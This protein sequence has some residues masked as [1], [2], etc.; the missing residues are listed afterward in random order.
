MASPS[1]GA[2]MVSRTSAPEASM[3]LKR[4]FISFPS[5]LFGEPSG[6]AGWFFSHYL[7]NDFRSN[8]PPR[9]PKIKII[10]TR[11]ESFQ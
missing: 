7:N 5:F 3:A 1:F 6:F 8:Y 9:R 4:Y 11:S 10:P 2:S